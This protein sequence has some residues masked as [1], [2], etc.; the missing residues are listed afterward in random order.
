MSAF[1][2]TRDWE[3]E[4]NRRAIMNGAPQG[5]HKQLDTTM[6]STI[7]TIL[8]V[9]ASIAGAAADYPKFQR[10]LDGSWRLALEIWANG[11]DPIPNEPRW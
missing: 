4:M 10:W 8:R 2:N 3:N 6:L 9:A 1:E 7:K 5:R 11:T